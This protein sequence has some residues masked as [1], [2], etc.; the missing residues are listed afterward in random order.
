MC[1]A[2][3]AIGSWLT[4]CSAGGDAPPPREA[5]QQAVIDFFALLHE[6]RYQ[7]ATELYGGTYDELIYMNPGQ[8]PSDHAALLRNGCTMNGLQCLE[9]LG[10]TPTQAGSGTRFVFDVQFKNEDGSLFVLGPCCGATATEMPPLDTFLI[11]V[12]TTSEGRYVVMD[13]P[14]YVP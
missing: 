2:V 11:A 7:E 12:E 10:T 9:V 1:A 3:L 4:G 8:D 14:V 5:A 6:E 13:L